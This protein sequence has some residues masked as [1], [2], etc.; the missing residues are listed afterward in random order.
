MRQQQETSTTSRS[1]AYI[2]KVYI[3]KA[4]ISKVYISK[5]YI[6]KAY[7]SKVYIISKPK[8]QTQQHDPHKRYP[9][10]QVVPQTLKCRE[11]PTFFRRVTRQR[12]IFKK[13]TTP[14]NT[15]IFCHH[16]NEAVTC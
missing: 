13:F 2:S 15:S 10:Q 6:S 4:Y 5:A 14:S 12:V 9:K 3:S 11:F 16:V 7:I 8:Q 1:K